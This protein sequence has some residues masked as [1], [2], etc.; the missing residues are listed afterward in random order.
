MLLVSILILILNTQSIQGYCWQVGMNPQF[1]GKPTVSQI[2][3]TTININWGKNIRRIHCTDQF[4]VK[5]WISG[6]KKNYKLTEFFNTTIKSANISVTP[7]IDY[8]FETVAR[9]NKGWLGIDWNRAGQV[10]FRTI[11]PTPPTKKPKK[12]IETETINTDMLAYITI[13]TICL[14]NGIGIIIGVIYKKCFLNKD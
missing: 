5:F 4:L 6:D 9:E 1:V 10:T 7:F 12:K 11:K 8:T 2:N 13:Y 3:I 14:L